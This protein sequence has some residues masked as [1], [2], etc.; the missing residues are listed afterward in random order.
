MRGFFLAARTCQND[1]MTELLPPTDYAFRCF[2]GVPLNAGLQ[3]LLQEEVVALRRQ[4][5]SH[6]VLWV[7]P[8]NWHLTLAFLG[9]QT[10]QFREQLQIRLQR[11]LE[12]VP[13]FALHS[14][15]ISG[16]PD[17]RSRIVAL[18][19]H[20]TPAL[21]QLKALVDNELMQ[22]GFQPELRPL[23]P[24][25]TLARFQRNQSPHVEPFVCAHEMSVQGV[26]L[27]RS[28]PT[29]AGSEYQP[30]WNIALPV[31]GDS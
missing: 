11:V 14:R 23:R 22:L 27:F 21:R 29:P 25:I 8:R 19:L 9:N 16:F 7:E 2:I 12:S 20:S 3:V 5:W 6:R 10:E 28:L 26:T 30:V 31:R 24:H 17:A 15:W 13:S 1:C 18:E 4:S